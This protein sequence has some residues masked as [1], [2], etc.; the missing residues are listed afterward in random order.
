MDEAQELDEEVRAA[1]SQAIEDVLAGR[2]LVGKRF[3]NE[4]VVYEVANLVAVRVREALA[5]GG[6]T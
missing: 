5:P 6:P 3:H 4:A 2:G 1:V